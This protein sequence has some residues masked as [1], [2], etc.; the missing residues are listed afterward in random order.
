MVPS[1]LFVLFFL[2]LAQLFACNLKFSQGTHV[3]C[4]GIKIEKIAQTHKLIL[5]HCIS[6]V[7]YPCVAYV[8]TDFIFVFFGTDHSTCIIGS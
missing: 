8:P 4:F 5:K 6:C 7:V 1:S 2:V 3:L